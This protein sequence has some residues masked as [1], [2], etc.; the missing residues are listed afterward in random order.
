MTHGYYNKHDCICKRCGKP[1]NRNWR[2]EYCGKCKKDNEHADSVKQCKKAKL[3]RKQNGTT[4]S[5]GTV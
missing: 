1:T 3:K 4:K 5:K 2:A